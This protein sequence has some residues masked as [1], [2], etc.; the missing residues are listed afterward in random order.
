VLGVI[1]N[2]WEKEREDVDEYYK[3]MGRNVDT[4][5]K[6]IVDACCRNACNREEFGRFCAMTENGEDR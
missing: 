6:N 5:R 3:R 4:R 2:E 1:Y